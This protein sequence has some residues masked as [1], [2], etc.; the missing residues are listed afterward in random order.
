[1]KMDR[2]S[3]VKSFG[4]QSE[5][6]NSGKIVFIGSEEACMNYC[7]THDVIGCAGDG[8]EYT[9]DI[10]QKYFE[11]VE[12]KENWKNPI[13]ACLVAIDEKTRT[14]ISIAIAFFTGSESKWSNTDNIWLVT[15]PGYYL[16]CGA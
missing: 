7:D 16:T 11:M 9:R 12:D 2:M 3:T 15:A 14:M 8:T 13:K 5:V 1:M 6:H 10:L 4:S